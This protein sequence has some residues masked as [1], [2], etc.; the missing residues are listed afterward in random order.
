MVSSTLSD[1]SIQ[2]LARMWTGRSNRMP[3]V[4]LMLEAFTT[5]YHDD[6]EAVR[7]GGRAI[8]R[9][10]HHAQVARINRGL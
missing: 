10:A 6:L 7:I 5:G 8:E 4:N 2:P 9:K 1:T 3:E